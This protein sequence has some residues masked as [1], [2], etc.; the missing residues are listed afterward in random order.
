VKPFYLWLEYPVYLLVRWKRGHPWRKAGVFIAS[1]L[2]TVFAGA[3]L[4]AKFNV[5]AMSGWT[6]VAGYAGHPTSASRGYGSPLTWCRVDYIIHGFH[7]YAWLEISNWHWL[8]HTPVSLWV[9]GPEVVSVQPIFA[10][11]LWMT[12]LGFGAGL[13]LWIAWLYWLR[14]IRTGASYKDSRYQPHLQRRDKRRDENKLNVPTT[15]ALLKAIADYPNLRVG[16]GFATAVLGGSG[17]LEGEFLRAFF[18]SGRKT[19]RQLAEVMELSQDNWRIGSYLA[20]CVLIDAGVVKRSCAGFRLP[21]PPNVAGLT[22][23]Q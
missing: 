13:V 6:S 14:A 5:D 23:G 12:L 15:Q 1:I 16:Y 17:R 9:K 4:G 20:L 8:L 11:W 21:M 19:L 18:T 3:G 2:L 10:H 22:E 7:E